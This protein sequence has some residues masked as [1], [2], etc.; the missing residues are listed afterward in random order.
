MRIIEMAKM[1]N[2]NPMLTFY[3]CHTHQNSFNVLS[4][5]KMNQQTTKMYRRMKV[6]RAIIILT[7]I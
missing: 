5:A 6:R 3:D 7:D 1:F 4:T 2:V